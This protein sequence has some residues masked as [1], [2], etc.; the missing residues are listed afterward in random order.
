MPLS[1]TRL[2]LFNPKLGALQLMRPKNVKNMIAVLPW[3]QRSWT[4][5]Q[6]KSYRHD[7]EGQSHQQKR[8]KLKSQRLEPESGYQILEVF[9]S[10]NIASESI[11]NVFFGSSLYKLDFLHQF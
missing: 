7:L 11:R 5:V 4:S 10:Q 3:A 1:E 9:K 6:Y 8:Q 2:N